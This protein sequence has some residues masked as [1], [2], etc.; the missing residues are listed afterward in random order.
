MAAKNDATATKPLKE[1]TFTRVL[2]APRDMVFRAWTDPEQLA[3]WWGPNGF[4]NPICELDVRPG[5]A[6]RIDMLGPDGRYFFMGGKYQEIVP[7]E[8]LVFTITAVKN[9]RGE[10]ELVNINTVTFEPMAGKTRLTFLTQVLKAGPGSEEFMAGM[11]EGWSQ[12][13]DRM[14]AEVVKS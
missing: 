12:T 11:E 4:T 7:P 6:I 13:L 9:E 3:R 14:V 10:P 8:R 1:L 5:G 2:D